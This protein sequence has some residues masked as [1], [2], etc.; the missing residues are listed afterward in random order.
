MDKTQFSKVV[1]HNYG[2]DE[3]LGEEYLDKF[4]DFTIKLKSTL[5]EPDFYEEVIKYLF[6]SVLG[7]KYEVLESNN[8]YHECR[9]YNQATGYSKREIINLIHRF[10]LLKIGDDKKDS[11]ILATLF[12]KNSKD[13]FKDIFLA[14]HNYTDFMIRKSNSTFEDAWHKT[15]REQRTNIMLNVWSDSFEISSSIVNFLNL[16]K[17]NI[18]DRD[19]FISS[20]IFTQKVDQRI[21]SLLRSYS[22]NSLYQSNQFDLK[23][24][25]YVESG[26]GH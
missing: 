13:L 2:Y 4:V 22:I 7:Y 15:D 12:F 20:P 21:L 6:V 19:S 1:C 10:S 23:W 17:Q 11:L 24:F 5:N 26:I 14:I 16:V 25:Q 9:A 8:F 3:K 18:G